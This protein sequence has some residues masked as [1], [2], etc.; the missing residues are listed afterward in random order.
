MHVL[1]MEIH[2]QNRMFGFST[3]GEKE[4]YWSKLAQSYHSDQEYIVGEGLLQVITEKLSEENK[5]GD[6]IEFGCGAGYFTKAIAE[7]A[8]HVIATDLSDEMLN[9]AKLHLQGF[10]NITIQKADCQ[11][12]SFPSQRFDTVFIANVIHVVANPLKVLQE[13]HQILKDGGLLLVVD[14]TAYGMK[15][16]ERIKM[17]FRY[18]R[19]WRMP[20]RQ[21]RST[22]SPDQLVTAVEEVGFRTDEPQLL[23]NSTKA[24]YLRAEK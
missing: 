6:V 23:G 24:L 5:L 4:H 7:A 13:S 12:T 16:G 20:P 22:L 10:G 15:W 21:G 14:F 2:K 19:K 17:A 11:D 1:L 18:F 9:M 3:Q 8:R